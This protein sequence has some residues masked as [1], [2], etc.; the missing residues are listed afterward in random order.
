[1][2]ELVRY[3]AKSGQ[4]VPFLGGISTAYVNFSRDGNWVAYV[5][6]PDGNLWRSRLDGSEKLQLTTPPVR[7]ESAD[8]SPDGR[9]IAYTAILPGKRENVFVVSASVGEARL[10]AG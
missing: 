7:A 10:I 4:F 1:R 9:Q 2:S 3:D 6:W 5:T 8:W